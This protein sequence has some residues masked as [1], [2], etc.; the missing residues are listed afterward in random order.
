[1][2]T[3]LCMLTVHQQS[4]LIALQACTGKGT[5]PATH[6][7]N[8]QRVMVSVEDEG[9][10]FAGNMPKVTTLTK[11]MHLPNPKGTVAR[12][13]KGKRKGESKDNSQG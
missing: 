10:A 13:S 2:Q 5:I 7:N 1:M 3:L 11:A 9:K 4:T 12:Q 8:L 6:S